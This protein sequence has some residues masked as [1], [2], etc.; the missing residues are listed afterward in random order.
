MKKKL[1]ASKS[2]EARWGLL[3]QLYED[4]KNFDNVIEN[5]QIL[6]QIEIRKILG[7]G[8]KKLISIRMPE[9]D[10]KALKAL[11]KK[12]DKSYQQLA[13]SAI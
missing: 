4:N 3:A 8:K 6:N 10:L 11:S 7:Q 9:E 2:D 5:S 12:F 1:N 13:I